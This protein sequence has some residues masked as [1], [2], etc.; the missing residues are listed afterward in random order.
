MFDTITHD[1]LVLT[2]YAEDAYLQ[3]AIATVKDRALT[4]VDGNKPVH[5][6][7]LFAMH[8]LGLT[9]TAKPV[10]SARVVGDVIGKYHPHGD[11]AAYDAMVRMAQ[12]FA[13]RYPLVIG[14]GNFGSRDGDSAAAMRYT[15]AR[16]SRFAELLLA[17]L[18][19]GTVDYGPNYDGS[20]QEPKVM[21]A[22]LPMLL[23]NGTT[24]IAVGMASNIPSH[25]L[26]EVA[27]ACAL[28]VSQPEASLEQVLELMPG[29]DF[30]DGAQL[31]ASPEEIRNAY[32][33]GRGPLRCRARWVKE[34]L[35]RGQWQLVITQMPYQVSTKRILEELD[36]LT[37]PQP[38]SG[39]K[40]ITQE[41]ANL[42]ALALEYLEKAVDES[43]KSNPVR[44]VI[45]PRTSKVDPEAMVAFLM[46]N[47]SLEENFSVNITM[48]G[49]DGR[50]QSKNLMA[51][52][53]E[54]AQFRV[55]TVRRRTQH[56]LDLA[57]RRAHILQGRLT[58]FLN[59]DAVIRVIR[60]ADE[61]RAELMESFSLSEEQALDILEMRL[62]QLNKLEGVK[63]EAELAELKKEIERCE[64]LLASEPLLR[65]LI[66]TE[67]EADAKKYGDERRT[68]IKHE[69]RASA[70]STAAPSVVDEPLTVV[71]SKNLWVKAYKG[72]EVDPGSMQFKQGDSLGF[73]VRTRS[74]QPVVVFDSKGRVYSFD[75]AMAP[76]G[77]GDGS[78]LS[79]FI[80]VQAGARIVSV[81]SGAP[82]DV[83]LFA[84]EGGCGFVAPFKGLV[85]RPRAGKVFMTL[86]GAERPLPVL[87]VPAGAT[88]LACGSSDARLLVFELS[89]LKT[90]E[91]GGKG[92]TLMG[93]DDGQVLSAVR[94]LSG[95]ERLES[96]MRVK[97]DEV[98]FKISATEMPKHVGKRARKGA[99]MPKK[100]VFVG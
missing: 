48:V 6:R 32:E 49:L 23:L 11:T 51:V 56:E 72:H 10:K 77:R 79:T 7:I 5:R 40:A 45:S 38:P 60:E 47:T 14:Q 57:Q 80:E 86:E 34:D 94:V 13:L 25:N 99:Q 61:P 63:L 26:V 50:P 59:L 19:Q 76:A 89:E 8:Q 52:L 46:A 15:E 3:Y 31:V 97:A 24:G 35:A 68:L 20:T 4:E 67:L 28:V 27:R 37:N 1:K 93:L 88:H 98:S 33:S 53:R 65:A 78:P 69:A 66:V 54:W 85:A 84:G 58:V 44:L 12:P 21:P 29:P 96:R 81:L 39:K 41:Q 55:V 43:D 71:V 70:R 74:T 92:T 90:Y 82:E 73:A 42:K 62:R 16:L 17:E 64:R 91:K 75:A 22:R 36:T 100:G 83:F 2:D 87:P 18:G 30:P 95:A 9:H